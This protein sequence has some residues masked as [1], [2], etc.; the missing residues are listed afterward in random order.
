MPTRM[1]GGE[2]EDE[3][4]DDPIHEIDLCDYVIKSMQVTSNTAVIKVQLTF[5]FHL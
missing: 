4:E 2:E 5:D 1:R 3:D